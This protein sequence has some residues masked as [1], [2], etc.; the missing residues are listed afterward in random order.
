MSERESP[1]I[2]LLRDAVDDRRIA[3]EL[4]AWRVAHERDAALGSPDGVQVAGICPRCGGASIK[5]LA[6]HPRLGFVVWC[7]RVDCL[8]VSDGH[9]EDA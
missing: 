7:D 6:Q 9:G 2:Q 8:L 4:W 5:Y 1:V 3:D